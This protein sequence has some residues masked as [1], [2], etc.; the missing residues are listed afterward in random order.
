MRRLIALVLLCL[1]PLQLA[2]AGVQSLDGHPPGEPGVSGWHV[3]GDG[4]EDHG[5]GHDDAPP[6]DDAAA[7]GLLDKGGE[8]HFHPSLTLMVVAF[9]P[10]PASAKPAS[11]PVAPPRAFASRTPPLFDRPPASR[12]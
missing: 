11:P 4:D 7:D 8:S 3:H 9:Y 12:G 10:T 6:G 1:V 2:W 5:H